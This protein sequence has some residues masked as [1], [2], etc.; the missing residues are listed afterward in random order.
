MSN[1]SPVRP[2]NLGHQPI[3]LAPYQHHD[4][5]YAGL[6][7]DARFLSFGGAQWDHNEFALKLMRHTGDV[8]GQWSPQA[9][10]LPL[11]RPID[12]TIL[13]VLLMH[14]IDEPV[15]T[16]RA[17]T[18]T[19]QPEVVTLAIVASAETRA[20]MKAALTDSA[21]VDRVNA[22]HRVLDMGLPHHRI[23]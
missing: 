13:L 3:V 4:G 10:E 21:L 5:P 19:N 15:L 6:T 17:H 2:V 12:L 23:A 1:T 16:V 20:A 9:E 7:T 14:Q 11:W 8:G 18:F 22:L